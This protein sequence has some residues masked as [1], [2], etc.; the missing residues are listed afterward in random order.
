MSKTKVSRKT[1]ERTAPTT[2]TKLYHFAIFAGA[3]A[4][5][6]VG[7]IW[8][9]GQ[10]E[11]VTDTSEMLAIE[12]LRK[13]VSGVQSA[14]RR[15]E[16]R[17][18]QD[19]MEE[20]TR[21]VAPFI[22]S[23]QPLQTTPVLRKISIYRTPQ[24]PR[25]LSAPPVMPPGMSGLFMD[26]EGHV[27]TSADVAAYGSA[28][29]VSFGNTRYA[30]DLISVDYTHH[31]ALVK[32]RQPLTLASFPD[33]QN[34]P[35]LRP[36][37][38]L[39]REGRSTSGAES[40]SLTLLESIHVTA[41]GDTIGRVNTSGDPQLDGAILVDLSGRI[42]G[43]YIRPE[44]SEDFVIPIGRALEVA[45]RLKV[46]PITKPTSWVGLE[47]QEVSDDL[48]DYF[49]APGGALVTSVMIDSP[50]A[51]AGLRA[52]DLIQTVSGQAVTS[53]AVVMRAFDYS[54]PGTEIILGVRRATR[55]FMVTVTVSEPPV[56][57]SESPLA[58][59]ALVLEL[60]PASDAGGALVSSIRPQVRAHELGIQ[61]GDVIQSMDGARI[62]TDRQFWTRQ[63]N[64]PPG[65]SQLWGIRRG[66]SFFFVAIR[67]KVTAP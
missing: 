52:M 40:R 1:L 14:L 55:E 29:D 9:G 21:G 28:L 20:I 39:V 3:A 2:R 24:N 4:V 38:W 22:V 18:I 63:R 13:E 6:V 16:L 26:R 12:A 53:P 54:V 56:D 59:N 15:N 33:F 66:D 37:E 60:S 23:L 41:T 57:D 58:E 25:I 51:R 19:T 36:G 43:V 34:P 8:R 50:A 35:E 30:A 46:S 47:L 45:S 32:V 62:R 64:L 27:L 67:E 65:K 31:L 5:L 48:K 7:G 49:S 61:P 42:A 10:H 44:D 11:S 17:S